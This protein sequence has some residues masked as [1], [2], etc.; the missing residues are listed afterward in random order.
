MIDREAAY[1]RRERERSET[2]PETE[3]E[4]TPQ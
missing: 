4:I 1:E 3:K 2:G